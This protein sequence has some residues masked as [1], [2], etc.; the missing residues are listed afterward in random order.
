MPDD[1]DID[2]GNFTRR[3][4]IKISWFSANRIA[5][6]YLGNSGRD[7]A[8]VVMEIIC[9]VSNHVV[10]DDPEWILHVILAIANLN[11]V[12]F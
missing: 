3:R 7:T 10:T 1:E 8:M 11:M 4:S 6:R 5:M 2:T 12:K 9:T